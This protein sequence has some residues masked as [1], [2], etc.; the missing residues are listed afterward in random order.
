MVPK[1]V[2]LCNEISESDNKS[3]IPLNK[4]VEDKTIHSLPEDDDGLCTV[5]KNKNSDM[6][7]ETEENIKKGTKRI[8]KEEFNDDFDQKIMKQKKFNHPS[9]R[10]T[11]PR[12]LNCKKI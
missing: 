9:S 12:K 4:Y 6:G 1:N 3:P 10:H 7:E 2:Y 5:C 11:I 8:F